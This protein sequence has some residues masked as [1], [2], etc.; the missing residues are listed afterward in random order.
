MSQPSVLHLHPNDPV[1]I[2]RRPLE[3]G[4]W[5]ALPGEAPVQ[6]REA[7]PAGHKVALRAIV[8][9]GAVL[10][11]GQA[12]GRASQDIPAG[13]WVHTHNLSLD[14]TDRS[15]SWLVVEPA[16]PS[17][18]GRT[19]LGYRRPGGRVGTRNLIAVISSVNCSAHVASEI[20]R[21]FPRERL[22]DFH[23]VDGVVPMVHHSGCSLPIEG[24]AHTFLR[25]T[26]ANLGRNPNI[27]AAIY[28]GLGCELNQVSE[29]QPVFEGAELGRL[30]P[31]SLVIQEQGGFTP[32]VEAG[33]RLVE[34]LL[35]R[36][37][38]MERTPQPL[39]ALT[40]ALECGG[41]DSW[42]GVSA[43]PLIG[44]V[45]DRVVA[46]GGTAALAETPEVFGAEALLTS[47][48]TSPAVAQ[49]LIERF[50]WWSQEARQ[51]GFSL[52]NN[53]TPGNKAGGLTT[54]YEKSLGAVAKAGSTPL[55]GV[56]S[57]SEW[58]DRPGLVFMDTPGNDPISV[59]GLLAG[60]CNLI[61]FSTGRG[62][63]F[64]SAVAPCIK[65]ASHTGL[66][67]R[68]PGDMDFNAGRVLEGEPWENVSQ[69]L[70]DRVVA[71]ASGQRTCSESH[72]LSEAEFVPWQPGDIL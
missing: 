61:L 6:V 24:L 51:H 59:T 52:D 17:L 10:R 64:G 16:I 68:M 58:I 56:Y 71:V 65:V 53:P 42:S 20:A 48:V 21:A 49:A 4:E 45:V 32:T 5:I 7:I 22:A 1:A 33:V 67:E 46:E 43:N 72:G 27:A 18:S 31:H 39:S 47:R 57:Y 9:G 40:L 54:I 35:P 19:F 63:V 23:H 34:E 69:D 12:I 60:G 11:Y 55:N 36:V 62:S 26:L 25:R 30:S 70:L 14:I 38:A 44:R 50:D 3:P 66:F 41:S 37:N 29:C 8:H 15:Y 13:S 2:A 28:V